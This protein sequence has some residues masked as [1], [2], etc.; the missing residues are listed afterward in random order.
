MSDN[1]SLA[2][3]SWAAGLLSEQDWTELQSRGTAIAEG[4]EVFLLGITWPVAATKRLVEDYTAIAT[5]ETFTEEQV[6]SVNEFLHMVIN[7]F[8]NLCVS[9]GVIDSKFWNPPSNL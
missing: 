7:G 6:D 3:A 9:N 5:T 4:S 1:E 8:Y 2:D